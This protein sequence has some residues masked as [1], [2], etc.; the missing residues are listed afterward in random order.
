MT[1]TE[2]NVLR[3]GEDVVVVETCLCRAVEV[4]RNLKEPIVHRFA[5]VRRVGRLDRCS[6][7]PEAA[8]LKLE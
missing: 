6:D 5:N 1:W 2:P 8:D 4:I 7:T 3:Y